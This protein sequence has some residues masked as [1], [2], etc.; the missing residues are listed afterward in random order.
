ML[1]QMCGRCAPNVGG[2]TTASV[3]GD[4]CS[5][6]HILRLSPPC[7]QAAPPCIVSAAQG[8]P[9]IGFQ[10]SKQIRPTS[11]SNQVASSSGISGA[12][13]SSALPS[14]DQQSTLE[15]TPS[16]PQLADLGAPLS[17]GFG[18]C[19]S[20][21]CVCCLC[22]FFVKRIQSEGDHGPELPRDEYA[23]P[24]ERQKER[25]A[26]QDELRAKQFPDDDPE[27]GQ[28]DNNGRRKDS[29][30]PGDSGNNEFDWL[31]TIAEQQWPDVK[32]A[33]SVSSPKLLKTVAATDDATGCGC[34]DAISPPSMPRKLK[35]RVR[36]R[37]RAP[38]DSGLEA[39]HASK[40]PQKP[41]SARKGKERSAAATYKD[42]CKASP[43]T[44]GEHSEPE[45]FTQKS[46][47]A[48]SQSEGPLD[49]ACRIDIGILSDLEPENP[50]LD[51]LLSS[52]REMPV[53][54]LR[55]LTPRRNR[56]HQKHRAGSAIDA[57]NSP[58]GKSAIRAAPRSPSPSPSSPASAL[59]AP[60]PAASSASDADTDERSSW[61][62]DD[63]R[64]VGHH[65]DHTPAWFSKW[66]AM[67]AD[68]SST[69]DDDEG[70]GIGFGGIPLS[71]VS[72]C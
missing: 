41:R 55:G 9:A 28:M 30:A 18:A 59:V 34:L 61:M 21:L 70:G 54:K 35:R 37:R 32:S 10:G 38:E 48:E 43:G 25:K 4:S 16:G 51:K 52:V 19:A 24:A 65:K 3:G 33:S 17:M 60:F 23:K 45:C 64:E 14:T 8:A 50:K 66:E 20:C 27:E 29:S 57:L 1:P 62:E 69:I 42:Q 58:V 53:E 36:K 39:E 31:Y 7:A 12:I 2:A 22:C 56:P 46:R 40:T 47:L 11:G 72:R 6:Q 13:G 71:H 26:R 63:A 68:L 67:Q 49:N 5:V 15:E 44:D